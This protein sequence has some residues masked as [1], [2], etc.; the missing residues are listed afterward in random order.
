MQ[1]MF[2]LAQ[3]IQVAAEWHHVTPTRSSHFLY[4]W[5][6]RHACNVY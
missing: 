5:D 2:N 3:V 4:S 6:W 1:E